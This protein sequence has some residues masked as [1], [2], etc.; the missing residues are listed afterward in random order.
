M[1]VTLQQ[2]EQV[3][4]PALAGTIRNAGIAGA[5]GAG[6][7]THGKWARLDEVDHLMVNHQ[8]S[9]PNYYIDKWL[10]REHADELAAFFDAV[11]DRALET[12]VVAAKEKERERWMGDLEAATDA[13]VY[14][15]SD[16]PLDPDDE[17]G[18][19]FAYTEDKYQ[20]G[21]ESVLLRIVADVVMGADL[22]MDHGWIVQNT[23]TLINVYRTLE[24]GTPL[25][26]KLVH[27]DGLV[28][29][30]RFLEVPIGTPA[31]RLL[32][33]A[34]VDADD[35]DDDELLLDGGP[36]WCFEIDHPPEEFGVRKRTNCLLVVDEKTAWEH[37]YGDERVNVLEPYNWGGDHETEPTTLESEPDRVRVPLITNPGFEGVV[38][39]TAGRTGRPRRRRRDDSDA[40]RRRHQQRPARRYRRNGHRCD[41]PP[42]RHRSGGARPGADAGDHRPDGL[43]DVV[44]GVR[45]VR[46]HARRRR[47][48]RRFHG[49]R[50]PGV[51]VGP[52]RRRIRP[53][54]PSSPRR[55]T[56]RRPCSGPPGPTRPRRRGPR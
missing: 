21:M 18:V 37:Q 14:G 55:R 20:Y 27:V 40:C 42:R 15:P 4:A 13:A 28:P 35:L 53:L 46:R 48:G 25:T 34:G 16:L 51:P 52:H 31:S 1:S 24:E 2:L 9:E 6:F 32:A 26:T 54:W 19:V 43:L 39:P 8:E 12:V 22:P 11:L 56:R 45:R 23:E 3:E 5:G 38:E 44:R 50:L 41:R 17:S 30:H 49:G 10:G 47:T 36:G 29:E 33:E 7:P